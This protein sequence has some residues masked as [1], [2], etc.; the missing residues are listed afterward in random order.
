MDCFTPMGAG[1]DRIH[2]STT[3]RRQ[4]DIHRLAQACELGF[5]VQDD[6]LEGGFAHKRRVQK[7]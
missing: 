6:S 4:Q 7:P 3:K 5:I 1:D 2:P